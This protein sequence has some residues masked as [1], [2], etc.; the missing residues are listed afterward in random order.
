MSPDISI[1]DYDTQDTVTCKAH[2]IYD[3]DRQRSLQHFLQIED[4]PEC[5]HTVEIPSGVADKD[6]IGMCYFV[7]Q[8]F[9]Q[10]VGFK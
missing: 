1:A 6:M 3:Q 8:V 4:L 5:F 10:L 2:T 7:W 9:T